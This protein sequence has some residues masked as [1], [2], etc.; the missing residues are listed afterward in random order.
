[1]VECVTLMKKEKTSKNGV[2]Q[3]NG[4]K[5]GTE[6]NGIEQKEVKENSSPKK[7]LHNSL[8]QIASAYSSDEDSAVK[9][10][11]DD[12]LIKSYKEKKERQKENRKRKF[13]FANGSYFGL[14]KVMLADFVLTGCWNLNH[15]LGSTMGWSGK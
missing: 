15:F 10:K 3:V 1:M 5:S 11:D 9:N 4:K 2:E 7:V 14:G 6:Q 13:N 8:A 12:G